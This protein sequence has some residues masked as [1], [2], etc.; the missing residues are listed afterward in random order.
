MKRG[1]KSFNVMIKNINQLTEDITI[2]ENNHYLNSVS[3]DDLLKLVSA[4]IRRLCR[5][6]ETTR[7]KDVLK[8]VVGFFT[9]QVMEDTMC[10]IIVKVPH[11]N[12][13]EYKFWLNLYRELC[14]K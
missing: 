14:K 10:D 13:L 2:I 6:N 9:I 3:D 12:P 1:Q 7:I 4:C 8:I 5:P 11:R